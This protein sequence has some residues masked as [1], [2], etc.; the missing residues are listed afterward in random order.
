MIHTGSWGKLCCTIVYWTGC[1]NTR[2]ANLNMLCE[3]VM[4]FNWR[5]DVDDEWGKQGHGHMCTIVYAS[6]QNTSS[7]GREATG[8]GHWVCRC[9]NEFTIVLSVPPELR[10]IHSTGNP[11]SCPFPKWH[12]SMETGTVKLPKALINMSRLMMPIF[13]DI[14]GR[15]VS[16]QDLGDTIREFRLLFW[17]TW[18]S[19]CTQPDFPLCIGR[20]TVAQK[21]GKVS[22]MYLHVFQTYMYNMRALRPF[23]AQ[24]FPIFSNLGG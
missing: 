21:I 1:Q 13:I 7:S 18:P 10:L 16:H 12:I 4:N 19:S 15:F 22:G 2:K 14:R 20:S 8:C 9:H 6:C 24:K 17:G 11:V 5:V 3:T 23:L